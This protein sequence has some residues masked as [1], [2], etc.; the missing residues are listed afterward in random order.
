MAEEDGAV[1]TAIELWWPGEGRVSSTRV[2]LDE[3]EVF[4]TPRPRSS[5]RAPSVAAGASTRRSP[6]TR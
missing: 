5:S 2:L 3:D 6:S 4:T 1:V